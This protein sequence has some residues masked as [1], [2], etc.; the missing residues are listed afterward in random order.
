M[1]IRKFFL[2]LKSKFFVKPVFGTPNA[3]IPEKR[4]KSHWI[5]W[6]NL[7]GAQNSSKRPWMFR[8]LRR[9]FFISFRLPETP[10]DEQK[11]PI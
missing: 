5:I 10:K 11:H 7:F 8:P 2:I 3:E 4:G 6:L 9:H 1:L